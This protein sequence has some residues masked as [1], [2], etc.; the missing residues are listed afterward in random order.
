MLARVPAT[1]TLRQDLERRR[2]TR[3]ADRMETVI[4]E[5]Q[6]RA[7]YRAARDGAVPP[8]LRQAIGGLRS[9]VRSLRRRLAE[10]S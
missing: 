2:L 9:E 6:R 4:V 8:A 10:G 1:L 3:R 5:L 7:R